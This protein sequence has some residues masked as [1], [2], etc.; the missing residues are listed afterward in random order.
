MTTKTKIANVTDATAAF[1]K[2]EAQY[3]LAMEKAVKT[4]EE[5]LAFGQGNLEAVV[6]SSQIFAAGLQDIGK[7]LAATARASFEESI[8]TAKAVAG[9]KSVTEAVQV[10]SAYAR[11][12]AERTIAESSKLTEVSLKLVEQASAPLTARATLAIEKFAKA[13]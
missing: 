7:H 4:A 2:G 9:S 10:Q 1:E 13:A 6:K 3:K 12:A 5:F 8:A 11:A